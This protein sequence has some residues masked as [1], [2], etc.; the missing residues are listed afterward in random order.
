MWVKG[1]ESMVGIGLVPTLSAVVHFGKEQGDRGLTSKMCLPFL[2]DVMAFVSSRTYGSAIDLSSV[3]ANSKTVAR[4]SSS[5]TISA[6]TPLQRHV[7]VSSSPDR[8][9]WSAASRYACCI[10]VPLK[11]ASFARFPSFS[12][13]IPDKED[14]IRPKSADRSTADREGRR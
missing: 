5:D 8:Q 6:I 11:T 12:S 7:R 3:F 13:A 1:I 2:S 4:L 9:D 14:C 10:Q